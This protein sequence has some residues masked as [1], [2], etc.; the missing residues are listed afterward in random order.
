VGRI[1]HR[2]DTSWAAALDDMI[3]WHGATHD[4]RAQWP[5]RAAQD[6]IVD[7]AQSGAPGEMPGG[8]TAEPPEE[9]GGAP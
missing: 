4:D 6:A 5:G 8:P 9:A 1:V 7:D 2:D 3:A